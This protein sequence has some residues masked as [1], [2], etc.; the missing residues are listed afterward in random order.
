MSRTSG[1]FS[2][3]VGNCLW[4]RLRNHIVVYCSTDEQ[5]Q[6]PT[7]DGTICILLREDGE[8]LFMGIER[9]TESLEVPVH[10]NRECQHYCKEWDAASPTGP[11][12]A[13]HFVSRPLTTCWSS[14]KPCTMDCCISS[15]AAFRADFRCIPIFDTLEGFVSSASFLHISSSA[16]LAISA[17]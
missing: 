4:H 11:C 16:A 12:V 13:C 2:R 8:D 10:L 3:N 6:G 14:L 15:F 17:A 1:S 9:V 7:K 5:R